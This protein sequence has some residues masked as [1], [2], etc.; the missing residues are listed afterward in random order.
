MY[1][2]TGFP[3]GIQKHLS[4]NVSSKNLDCEKC[5]LMVCNSHSTPLWIANAMTRMD[6]I[7]EAIDHFLENLHLIWC[8]GGHF[9]S[10]STEAISS[11]SHSQ[12]VFVQARK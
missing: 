11:S 6:R 3:S 9:L 10:D 2:K 5:Y 4:S 8:H 7:S 12:G 1:A